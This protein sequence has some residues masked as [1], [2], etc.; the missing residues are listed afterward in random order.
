M[1]HQWKSQVSK[2]IKLFVVFLSNTISHPMCSAF[3][4][5]KENMFIFLMKQK[6]WCDTVECGGWEFVLLLLLDLR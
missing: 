2:D 1:R 5:T 6:H 3:I 4:S